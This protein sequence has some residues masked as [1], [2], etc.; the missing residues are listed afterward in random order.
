MAG[1][2]GIWHLLLRGIFNQHIMLSHT[3]F[4]SCPRRE[5]AKKKNSLPARF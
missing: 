2:A 3:P 5:I 1:L 4:S